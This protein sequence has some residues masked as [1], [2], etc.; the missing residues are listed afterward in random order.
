MSQRL[1]KVLEESGDP[2]LCFIE[3]WRCGGCNALMY[4]TADGY[5][6]PGAPVGLTVT[7]DGR[8][9]RTC[10]A[11]TQM[12][13]AVMENDFLREQHNRWR[14]ESKARYEKLGINKNYL[15]RKD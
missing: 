12:Y 11:C 14:D 13:I 2:S 10:L 5:P 15:D 7:V 4:N 1:Q 6:S 9:I 8:E 3:P